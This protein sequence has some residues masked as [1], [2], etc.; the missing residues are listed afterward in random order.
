MKNESRIAFLDGLRGIAILL[1]VLFHAYARWPE[2]VPFG[3]TFAKFPIFAYGWLGVQLFFII[4]GFVICMTLEKCH[5]FQEFILRRWLRLFPAMLMCSIIIF[6]MA[7][8]FPERPAGPVF[9][10]NLLPGLTFI[11][12]GWW[13]EL[14]GFRI[15]GIEGAFWSLYV[16]VKFYIIFGIL[17]FMAGWRKAV[18]TLIGLFCLS[19]I[20]LILWKFNPNIDIH[21]MSNIVAFTSAQYYGWFAAGA[22]YYKYFREQR[23]TLL[24]Y[25]MAIAFTS[26]LVEGGFNWQPKLFAILLTVLFTLA[27]TNTRVQVLLTHPGLLF[28]GLISYPLYLLHE[29]MM[30]AMIIKIGQ[31]MPSMYGILI[32]ALPIAVVIGL[33]WFVTAYIEPWIREQLRLPYKRFCKLVGATR[34]SA[35]S[36]SFGKNNVAESVK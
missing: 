30:I 12:P 13:A 6:V 32:P 24:T 27:I 15:M 9:Y 28:I 35:N 20:F 26:A 11:E 17:Y 4:S 36:T 23:K 21:L 25:S 22:L 3:N 14:L 1:V 5:N 18:V 31:Q 10:C 8:L 29:N 7:P 19:I 16:E 2:L 33:G 34:R